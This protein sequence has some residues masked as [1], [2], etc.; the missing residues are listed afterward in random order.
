[1]NGKKNKGIG[2]SAEVFDEITKKSIPKKRSLW[3]PKALPLLR[4]K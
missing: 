4:K 1:M 3:K 2:P